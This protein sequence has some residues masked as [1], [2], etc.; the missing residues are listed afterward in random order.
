MDTHQDSLEQFLS[1][2][3]GLTGFNRAE[4][5]GTGLVQEYYQQVVSV[6]GE[7]ISQ[8]LWA[9][10]R[11]LIERAGNEGADLEAAI[12]RE[13]M[14][15]P[16]FGPIARN[17]VQLWYWGAWIELPQAWRNQHRAS[18]QD[19]TH[20]TSAAAY[21]QGLLWKTMGAHPQGAQQP[22]FGSW[23]MR[24]T[25]KRPPSRPASLEETI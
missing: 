20:F 19:V 17:I 4:L 23:S 3:V 10:A 18:P 8:E 12:R 25:T 1:L 15:S 2:S 21:Q 11:K 9:I 14:A 22:G 7:A 13:L 5:L 24:P 6:I 16:K